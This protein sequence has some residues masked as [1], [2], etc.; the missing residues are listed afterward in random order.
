MANN[1]NKGA[2]F[3]ND[4]KSKETDPDYKGSANLGGR[5]YWLAAWQQ[6]KKDGEQYLS[7]AFT[8][9]EAQPQG[10][11]GYQQPAQSVQPVPGYTPKPAYAGS[12]QPA[13]Q[14]QPAQQNKMF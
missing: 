3:T 9:Q 13:Y 8:E 11:T 12:Q 2:L 1:L 14:S 5:D 4:K 6:A 10:Q 7:I